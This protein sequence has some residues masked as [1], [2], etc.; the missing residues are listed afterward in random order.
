MLDIC[1]WWLGYAIDNP[2]RRLLHDPER[3]LAPFVS[4]GM[5]VLDVGCGRG[6]FSIAAARLVG[7]D[8][9][10]TS[11]DVQQRM[12]DAVLRRAAAAG[13]AGRIRPHRCEPHDL[14]AVGP[15]DFAV[16]FWMV[17]ETPDRAAFLRQIRAALR[18]G[19]RLLVAEPRLH[20]GAADFERTLD[21]ARAAG[22][23]VRPG[24][25]IRISRSAVLENGAAAA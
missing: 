13:L 23:T 5:S 4:R 25:R 6:L 17:H 14:G 16:A 11:A 8:G 9:T 19:G 2:V 21:L 7:P 15:V 22:L 1:P 20:V 24:P 3:L 18:P 10:V 12:L